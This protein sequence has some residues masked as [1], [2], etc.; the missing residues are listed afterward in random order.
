MPKPKGVMGSADQDGIW[1]QAK[2]RLPGIQIKTK[3]EAGSVSEIRKVSGQEH[4][5]NR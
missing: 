5:L 1:G 2:G 3:S 4:K